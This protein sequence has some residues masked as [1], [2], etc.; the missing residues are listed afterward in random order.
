MKISENAQ[1]IINALRS[2]GRKTLNVIL[3]KTSFPKSI[4]L[5][6]LNQL[7]KNGLVRVDGTLDLPTYKLDKNKYNCRWSG[8]WSGSDFWFCLHPEAISQIIDDEIEIP[9]RNDRSCGKH[10]FLDEPDIE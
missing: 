5:S 4:V 7:V 3:T 10:R 8:H 1:K 9:C 6:E 2:Y